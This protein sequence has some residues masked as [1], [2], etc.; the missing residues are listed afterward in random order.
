MLGTQRKGTGTP[1]PTYR[2]DAPQ[3]GAYGIR[4]GPSE[5]AD[6]HPFMARGAYTPYKGRRMTRQRMLRRSGIVRPSVTPRGSCMS[7]LPGESTKAVGLSWG[8]AKSAGSTG[9][10]VIDPDGNAATAGGALPLLQQAESVPTGRPL[11]GAGLRGLPDRA[12]LLAL[13]TRK[14]PT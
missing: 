1:Y 3:L 14:A 4:N 13:V 8:P 10:G 11:A 5:W 12:G 2:Q 6:C 9:S 7:C